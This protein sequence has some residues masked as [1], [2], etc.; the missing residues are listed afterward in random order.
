MRSPLLS[1][2]MLLL[3]T[4]AWTGCSKDQPEPPSKAKPAKAT[5]PVGPERPELTPEKYEELILGLASCKLDSQGIDRSCEAF[6]R[7]TEARGRNTV[8]GDLAGR[9][10]KLGIKLLGHKSPTVRFVAAGLLRSYSDIETAAQEAVLK[11]VPAE[12]SPS[13][14][15][16]LVLAVSPGA[17]TNPEVAKLLL[18]LADHAEEP[19]RLAVVRWLTSR[20]S[21]GVKGAPEKLMER[22]RRDPAPGVRRLACRSAGRTGDDRLVPIYRKLTQNPDADPE[23][24]ASCMRGLIEMWNP[25]MSRP[26]LSR[27]AYVLSLARMNE[28][29][30]GKNRPP[31]IIPKEFGRIPH[32]EPPWYEKDEVVKMLLAVAL[33]QRARWLARAGAV[34]ALG[35]LKAEHALQQVREALT[36]K[37]DFDSTS[38]LKTTKKELKHL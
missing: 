10:S 13:V 15:A 4:Q 29:P 16:Q 9:S 18:K 32:G 35:K 8:I 34:R 14:L 37:S 1:I 25:L 27:K 28:K 12:K 21:E 5:K 38:I 7:Y 22:I 20:W 26:K 17:K 30:R 33:D 23:T 2:L 19:V 3:V 6:K 36:G 31:W 11:A 24:Y